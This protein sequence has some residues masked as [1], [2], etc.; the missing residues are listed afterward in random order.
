MF[1][2]GQS[3]HH[4][5][6]FTLIEVLITLLVLSIGL[7]GLAG[8]QITGLRLNHDSQLRITASLLASDMAERMRANSSIAK[9][10]LSSAYHNP[11][12]NSL[13][14]PSCMG[15]G[16]NNAQCSNTQLALHDFYEWYAKIHGQAETSWH[17]QTSALLPNGHGVVCIDSTPQ[18]GSPDTP[19]CDGLVSA[20][21]VPIFTIKIW[22]SAG[23]EN[24][25]P[26]TLQRFTTSLSP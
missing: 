18:D 5:K 20:S 15:L 23:N 14:H 13:A 26:S 25:D 4:P 9:L 24:L 11:T 22:W 12:G 8:L 1:I 10:G 3:Y 6:G 16:G 7:I 21:G 2:V 17:S 19:E